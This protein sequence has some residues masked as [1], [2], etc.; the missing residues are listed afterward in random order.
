MGFYTNGGG[1][2]LND[3]SGPLSPSAGHVTISQPGS[4]VQLYQTGITLE[5]NTRYQLSFAAYST[6]GHDVTVRLFKHVSPYTVYMPEYTANL[7]MG[8]TTF[9]T[10]FTSSGFTGIVNDGRLMFWLA[11]YAAN[12][13]SIF[14]IM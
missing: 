3:V 14:L 12:G 7:G 8:W 6:M 13:I 1:T 9:S 2:F 11:P 5:P 4:N 10:E